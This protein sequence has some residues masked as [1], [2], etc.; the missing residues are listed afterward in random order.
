MEKFING[1]LELFIFFF[2]QFLSVYTVILHLLLSSKL[3]CNISPIN[4]SYVIAIYNNIIGIENRTLMFIIFGSCIII[5]IIIGTPV[6]KKTTNSNIKNIEEFI[7]IKTYK[8]YN[9]TVRVIGSRSHSNK[10]FEKWLI[11]NL[12]SYELVKIGSSLKFCLLA[13]GGA[14]IYPRLGPTSEWD[15][16]AGHIILE[17]AGGSIKNIDNNKIL[18]NTKENVINPFFIAKN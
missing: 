15:I 5:L 8:N 9:D 12:N 13:E 2:W 3:Q 18:Y 7:S 4:S 1:D 6:P 10:E 16:A 14:D 11:D 17:E